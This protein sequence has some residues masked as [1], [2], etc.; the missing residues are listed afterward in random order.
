MKGWNHGEWGDEFS[1]DITLADANPADYDALLLPGGVMNPDK[2]RTIFEAVNFAKTFFERGKPIASIC[3]GPWLLVE[4]DVLKG[5]K[6]TG[7]K[8]IKTDLKNA[9]AK[10]VDQEVVIDRG[11][12]TSRNPDDLPA[13]NQAMLEEFAEGKHG[14]N[15]QREP[16]RERATASINR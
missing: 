16:G 1:V 6:V 13:F 5:Y 7:Y 2:L 8:S 11:L 9:G 10:F 3:H 14:G 4:A 15:G 12:V